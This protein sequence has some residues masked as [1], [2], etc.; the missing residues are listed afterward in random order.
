MLTG[1]EAGITRD[2]IAIDWSWKGRWITLWDTAGIRRKSRVTGKVEK[3]AVA[4]AL[5]A[6]R[7]ADA[8]IVLIDASLEIER[9]DLTSPISSPRR[10]GR[11]SLPLEMGPGRGQAEAAERRSKRS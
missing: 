4:D 2:A 7:F 11:S 3:L 10:A 9:Q 8:V 1:P 6:I 5:R